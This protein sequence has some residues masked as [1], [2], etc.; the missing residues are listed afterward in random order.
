MAGAESYRGA[1]SDPEKRRYPGGPFDPMGLSKVSTT[2]LCIRKM[3]SC[4][5]LQ[6]RILC[7]KAAVRQQGKPAVCA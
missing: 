5:S 6:Q 4:T 7:S 3:I 2:R 1:E